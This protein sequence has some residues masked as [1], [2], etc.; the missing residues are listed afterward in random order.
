MRD[1]GP[2]CSNSLRLLQRDLKPYFLFRTALFTHSFRKHIFHSRASTSQIGYAKVCG[3]DS[4]QRRTSEAKTESREK[5]HSHADVS[6]GVVS[7][8]LV[9]RRGL[10]PSRHPDRSQRRIHPG[11]SELLRSDG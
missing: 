10:Q 6:D 7:R 8:V 5:L 9:E 11:T 2:K 4:R 3:D 1:A